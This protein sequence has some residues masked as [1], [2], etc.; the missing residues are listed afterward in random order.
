MFRSMTA[1]DGS[2][3]YS[4]E[5]TSLTKRTVKRTTNMNRTNDYDADFRRIEHYVR[6]PQMIPFVGKQWGSHSRLLILAESHYLPTDD[7]RKFSEAWYDTNAKD[8][9]VEKYRIFTSTAEIVNNAGYKQRYKRKGHRIFLNIE[10]AI[11]ESGFNPENTDNMFQYVAFMN[12]FQRPAE[13]TGKSITV[14]DRDRR[15]ANSTLRDVIRIIAPDFLFFVSSEAWK[16]YDKSLFDGDHVGHS[17]HPT[18]AWWNRKSRNYTKPTG[19]N[20]VSG[21]ESFVRFIQ[22]K[23]VFS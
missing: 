17:C 20:V 1:T 15:V 12:F 8:L 18:S 23:G 13:K 16:A 14:T 7:D 5:T 11:L 19:V 21:K 10:R 4:T 22:N 6:H 3:C 9:P 2:K